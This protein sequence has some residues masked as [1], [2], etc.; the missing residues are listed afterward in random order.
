MWRRLDIKKKSGGVEIPPLRSFDAWNASARC[1]FSDASPRALYLSAHENREK[2]QP[3]LVVK[4]TGDDG[5]GKA[6]ALIGLIPIEKDCRHGHK[7][8]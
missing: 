8:E 5:D 3:S 2:L 1:A 7:E 4:K 6:P